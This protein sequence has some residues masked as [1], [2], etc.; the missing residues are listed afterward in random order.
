MKKKII[1]AAVFIIVALITALLIILF[2]GK[3]EVSLIGEEKIIINYNEKYKDQGIV[4]KKNNKE[5]KRNKYIVG[6]SN[7]VDT[8]T[9]G[10]Y[11][12]TYKI[13][14]HFKE[15]TLT[16]KVI[17]ADL[18]KPNFETN[19]NTIR[20][21]YCSKENKNTIEYHA[22]DNYDGDITDKVKIEEK[23]DKI[24]Y[25]IKD[26]SGNEAV[27]EVEIVYDDIPENKFVLNGDEIIYVELNRDFNDPGASYLDGCGNPIE[28]DIKVNSNVD[29]KKE[30]EY[31]VNYMLNGTQVISRKVIVYE[32]KY[33]PKT[34]Y[35]TFDDGPGPYTQSILDTLAKYN[36]KAT[37][38]VTNQFPTYQAMIGEEHKQGHVIAVHTYTHRYDVVYS[39]V[40][41]YFN[42]FDQ[43]NEIIHS[44]TGYYSTLF[45]FPGGSSNTVSRRYASGVVSQ[46]AQ[47]A[48]NLGY[49]YFD[50]NLDSRDAEGF[51]SVSI[52]NNIIN[53]VENC[54]ACV[55]LMHDV[56]APTA[57]ALDSILA[58]LKKRGYTFATLDS[59]S[60]TAHH[61]I[62]N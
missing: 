46:I 47:T 43:M 33:A 31:V 49:T 39:S 57:D 23:D 41:A 15:Y 6:V 52:Y 61:R 44:Y 35:L 24:I 30:G 13:K 37:F 2:S 32:K 51:D 3:V 25:S 22:I 60:P 12:V 8:H 50:W 42:D 29:T 4:L 18:E 16:R 1:I 36:V 9:L 58:E 55:V 7:T 10:E 21:D 26:S 34:I 48:N 40:G 17:V 27:K 28:G 53:G 5:V 62:Q 11:E 59:A 19:T 54:S 14:Y 56:K 38:F 45:R 20:R